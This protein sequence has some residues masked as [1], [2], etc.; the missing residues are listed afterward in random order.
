MAVQDYQRTMLLNGI[1][2]RRN[3][4]IPQNVIIFKGGMILGEHTGM[5]RLTRDVD[6]SIVGN[7][8][9]VWGDKGTGTVDK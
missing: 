7:S 5:F 1:L 4:C 9:G 2:T 3:S 8:C 6:A